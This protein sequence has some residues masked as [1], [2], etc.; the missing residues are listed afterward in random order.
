MISVQ[1]ATILVSGVRVHPDKQLYSFSSRGKGEN[2][3]GEIEVQFLG[4][5]D[6]E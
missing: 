6:K 3:C 1:V 5:A 2:P 4:P